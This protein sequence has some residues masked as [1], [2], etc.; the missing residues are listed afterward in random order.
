MARFQSALSQS[1]IARIYANIGANYYAKGELGKTEYYL[2]LAL[3][4]NDN[5]ENNKNL[6]ILR[7][8]Q[9]DYEGTISILRNAESRFGTNPDI[10][11][12]YGCIYHNQNQD[13]AANKRFDNA[14]ALNP[15]HIEALINK[16]LSV[17]RLGYLRE[18]LEFFLRACG[19]DDDNHVAQSFKLETQAHMLMEG[20]LDIDPYALREQIKYHIKRLLDGKYPPPKPL[21]FSI[22]IFYCAL[23]IVFSSIGSFPEATNAFRSALNYQENYI[24]RVNLGMSLMC[25]DDT[26]AAKNEFRKAVA[27][28]CLMPKVLYNISVYDIIKFF[29]GKYKNK[30]LLEEADKYYGMINK[31][32]DDRNDIDFLEG[33]L[34]YAWSL[35]HRADC[36][37]A[38][39][40]LIFKRLV[41]NISCSEELS[42]NAYVNLEGIHK[43]QERLRNMKH[44]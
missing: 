30:E 22:S 25:C 23:G 27:D 40:E 1:D 21:E 7:F 42:I 20:L 15:K 12:L 34:I 19:V 5:I 8:Y 4:Y 43:L 32:G 29:D 44:Q 26:Q 16:G 37:L 24:I 3:K 41:V 31:M 35:Y 14:I 38:R 17:R 28:G 39:A 9:N 33:S 6:A 10:D 11:N 13:E 18:A 36:G 2:D